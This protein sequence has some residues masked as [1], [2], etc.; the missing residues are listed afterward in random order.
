MV[1]AHWQRRVRRRNG[2]VDRTWS[3]DPRWAVGS[4]LGSW[5]SRFPWETVSHEGL[6]IGT[7][8]DAGRNLLVRPLSCATPG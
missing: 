8:S 4:P 2:A 5:L 3:V 1:G 6:K 7:R